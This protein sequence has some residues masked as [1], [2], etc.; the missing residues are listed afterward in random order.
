MWDDD[1]DA[2]NDTYLVTYVHACMH[3]ILYIYAVNIYSTSMVYLPLARDS[4]C[5]YE[6]IIPGTNK[7]QCGLED[8]YVGFDTT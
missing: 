7:I 5:N 1:A 8:T 3:A 2:P 4:I 6:H